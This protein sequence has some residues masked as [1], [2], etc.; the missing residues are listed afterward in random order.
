MHYINEIAEGDSIREIYLCKEKKVLENKVGK[1]YYALTL[2]DKTGTLDAKVWDLNHGIEHFDSGD[3]IEVSGSV[4]LFRQQP[5]LNVTR[6]RKA[7]TGEYD[8]MDYIS[9]SKIPKQELLRQLRELI[10]KITHPKLRLLAEAL[11]SDE[12]LFAKFMTHSAAKSVH[13]NYMFG[14]MQHTVGV[15]RLCDFYADHYAV[16][17]DLVLTAALFHDVGKIRELT[18][19]PEN[20]YTEEGQLLGHIA[21]SYEILCEKIRGVEGFPES[22]AMQLKHCILAHHGKLEYGS[23]KVPATMEA[24]AL[25]LADLTDARFET[26]DTFLERSGAVRGMAGFCPYLETNLFKTDI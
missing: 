7:H 6:A 26:M 24:M 18:T 21:M 5:Q 12:N 19:M 10:D 15:M 11:C 4:V 20:V 16:N 22:L 13:H 23:P 14:L 9:T 17:R 1:K 2:Q 3:Y 8:L 25:H